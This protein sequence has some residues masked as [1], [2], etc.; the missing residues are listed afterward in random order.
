M[1]DKNK[2]AE[3]EALGYKF[4]VVGRNVLVTEAMKNY[5]LD[6]LTKI[7]RFH[8]HIM[9]VHAHL[10]IQKMEHTAAIVLKFNNFKVKVQAMSNDM[11]A[12][13]DKA[14]D[15]LQARL[16]DYKSK[17][18]DHHKKGWDTVE[19]KVSVWEAPKYNELEE[20]NAEIEAENRRIEQ[21]K[22]SM[23]QVIGME[24]RVLKILT[25]EEAMMKMDLSGDKFLVYR[26]EEDRKLKVIYRR[27]DGNYGIIQTE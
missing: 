7:E 5:I 17:I 6:K 4:H 23:P 21:E 1:V 2:F 27:D 20:I 25:T 19:M 13:I 12:S 10:D 9:D 15:R 11:Y 16:R 3:E 18:Q 24:T 22:V 14:V 26:G 8:N